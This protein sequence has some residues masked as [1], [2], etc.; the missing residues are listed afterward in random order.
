MEKRSSDGETLKYVITNL[1]F[2]CENVHSSFEM[3]RSF[4]KNKK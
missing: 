2:Y 3:D 1:V 4:E